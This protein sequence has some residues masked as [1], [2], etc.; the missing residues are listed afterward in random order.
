MPFF[1]TCID[2]GLILGDISQIFIAHILVKKKNGKIRS[3]RLSRSFDPTTEET[4][5]L[6]KFKIDLQGQV[7][8]LNHLDERNTMVCITLLYVFGLR[9]TDQKRN[10]K[11]FSLL[12]SA[13]LNAASPENDL[14]GNCSSL[15][16]LTAFTACRYVEFFFLHFKGVDKAPS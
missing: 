4:R 12:S 1:N 7:Y 16:G 11:H 15:D 8:L 3:G 5:K 6:L 9:V 2:I 14:Y 13:D 10:R